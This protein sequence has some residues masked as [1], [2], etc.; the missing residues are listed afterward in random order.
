MEGPSLPELPQLALKTN[1][2]LGFRAPQCHGNTPTNMSMVG[3]RN[4]ETLGNIRE[5]ALAAKAWQSESLYDLLFIQQQQWI[6]VSE[7]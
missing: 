6:S 1:A 3:V 4:Q 7:T 2:S 5:K